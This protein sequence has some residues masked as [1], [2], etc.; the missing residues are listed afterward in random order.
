MKI[1]CT[2]DGRNHNLSVNSNKPLLRILMEDVHDESFESRCQNGTCGNC[3]VFFNEEPKL[4]CLVP[5]FQLRGASITTYEGFEKTRPSADI[6]KAFQEAGARP[7]PHCIGSKTVLIESL[8]RSLTRE[9]SP[10]IKNRRPGMLPGQDVEISNETIINELSINSCGCLDPSEL[11]QIVRI[12]AE[13]R[14]RR[15]KN[16][17]RA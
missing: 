11:I 5:A 7:C 12:A 14:K 10:E 9:Q 1:E 6:R 3:I 17:R 13:L 15:N 16:V 4:A 2:I 8:V